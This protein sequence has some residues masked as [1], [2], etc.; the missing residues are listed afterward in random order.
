M[1]YLPVI[2]AWLAPLAA[3][4]IGARYLARIRAAIHDAPDALAAR[5]VAESERPAPGPWGESPR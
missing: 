4:A 5:Q 3:W 1:K 2:I